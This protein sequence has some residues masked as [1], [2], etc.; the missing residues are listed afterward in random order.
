[1]L[2]GI[3]HTITGG[4]KVEVFIENPREVNAQSMSSGAITV[5]VII[6]VIVLFWFIGMI[7]TYTKVGDQYS[8]PN[9]DA[10]IEDKKAPWALIF[11]SFNPIVNLQKLFTVKEGGDTTLDVLNGVRVLSICWIILGHSFAFV[12]FSSLSNSSTLSTL[13]DSDMFAIIPGG[14]FA[15]DTFFY[16]SGFLT[17]YLLTSKLYPK[18]GNIGL[19]NTFLIYFHR[20]YRLI[21]PLVFVQFFT[22]FVIRYFGD[23][24]IYR[25]NWDLLNQNC[26]DNPWSNFLFI[27]NF[28]PWQLADACIGWVWYLAND[29]QFFIMS[30]PIIYLY[31]KNRLIGKSMVGMLI[32]LSMLSTGIITII[33]NLSIQNESTKIKHAG[34][35]M[36]NKPW[37]RM[38]AYFV[39]AIFGLSYFELANKNKYG[40]LT[41]SMFNRIYDILRNSVYVS[42]LVCAVGI[43]LTALFIFPFNNFYR[44]TAT[45]T[46]ES[47]CWGSFSSFLFN[48]FSRPFFVLGVGLIIAPTFV[49]RLR[50]IKGFLG[51][52]GFVVLAR[53]NYM[54]YMIHCLV[55]FHYLNN[56]RAGIYATNV[57]QWFFAIGAIFVSFMIAIPVTLLCEVPF[58]NLEKNVLF[59]KKKGSQQVKA[60]ELEGEPQN[61]FQKETK[62]E[63]LNNDETLESKKRLLDEDSQ[64]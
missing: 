44:C 46:S 48:F 17:F 18:K 53:L 25:Q 26:F 54:V 41:N 34:D 50:A 39:G 40:E 56:T 6:G 24:P 58:M 47:H 19:V 22:M 16:L 43:G 36:Y 7:I 4:E 49:G 27:N 37:A 51:A 5:L 28:I 1:M 59:P 33:G 64:K 38:G 63:I 30:P 31:C 13:Y 45:N 29:M 32:F 57:S 15:V 8:D 11:H 23:G 21:F 9:G 61:Y 10:K 20:Y 60:E 35:L 12:Q 62:Y 14:E 2:A 52:Q 42:L 3:A 55:L